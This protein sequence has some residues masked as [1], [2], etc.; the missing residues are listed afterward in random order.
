MVLEEKSRLAEVLEQEEEDVEKV[1]AEETDA[2]ELA[3]SLEKDI[4]YMKAL[5]VQERKIRKN[6]SRVSEAKQKIRRRFIKRIR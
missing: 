3:D 5:K 2:D 6:L 4:D 1:D